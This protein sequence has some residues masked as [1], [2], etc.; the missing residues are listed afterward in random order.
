[1]S[2]WL[3]PTLLIASS[4]LASPALAGKL[5]RLEPEE[6]SHYRA[7]K[8]WMDKAETRQYLKLKTR[9]ARDAWLKDNGYWDRFY[10]YDAATRKQ[11]LEADVRV[12]W[13]E[14]MV[15]M[16][17]GPAHNRRKEILRDAARAETL[18][19]RFEVTPEGRVLVWTPKSTTYHN[20]AK[21]FRY[22]VLMADGKVRKM[23][24]KE[25]WG[26]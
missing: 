26:R 19:Y 17:W 9:E 8:V 10:Q 18:F 4:L 6:R 13:T 2:R 5:D 12:G 1:M 21:L 15:V 11:I 7:L 20:A 16:A 22:E 24:R 25:G 23:E 14:D 3:I